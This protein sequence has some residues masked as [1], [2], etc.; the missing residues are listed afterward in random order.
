[1]TDSIEDTDDLLAASGRNTGVIL[2][3]IRHAIETGVYADG[4]QLPAERQLAITF[5]TARPS[6]RVTRMF[7]GLMSRWMMPF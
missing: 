7:D 4:D 5:G 3:R 1:M 6:S 2:A